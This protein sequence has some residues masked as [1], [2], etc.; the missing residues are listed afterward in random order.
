VGDVDRGVHVLLNMQEVDRLSWDFD[1]RLAAAF[2]LASDRSAEAGDL[3]K[4]LPELEKEQALD[5]ASA[6]L[7]PELPR[8]GLDEP[9]FRVFGLDPNDA[10]AYRHL[11][12]YF[13]DNAQLEKTERMAERLL[14][15]RP[16][17]EEATAVLDAISKVPKWEP[18]LTP[19]EGWTPSF[20]SV[21]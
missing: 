6:A 18:V 21:Y 19:A 4:G 11:M 12:F 9:V 3:L 16:G 5:G 15:L 13:S 17:D 20:G 14:V 7:T 8:P 1:R 10:E 2:L